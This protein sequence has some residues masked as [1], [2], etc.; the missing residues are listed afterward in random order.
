MGVALLVAQTM[1]CILM[2]RHSSQSSQIKLKIEYCVVIISLGDSSYLF[3]FC[4]SSL[5][6]PK[7]ID[8]KKY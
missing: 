7:Q 2:W 1:L 3:Y 5:I 4:I 8:A 6:N